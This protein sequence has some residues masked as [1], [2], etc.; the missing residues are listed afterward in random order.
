MSRPR[1]SQRQRVYDAER[2]AFALDTGLILDIHELRA[3]VAEVV[4]SEWWH[5]RYPHIKEII[6]GDGRGRRSACGFLR[7]WD[8]RGQIK[9]PRRFR[10]K[11]LTLHEIAHVITPDHHSFHGVEFVRNLLL[12]IERFLGQGNAELLREEM[13]AGRVKF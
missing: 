9:M 5:K 8:S 1:D 6:V 2:R 13:M 3:W 4:A 10:F 11:W 12:L 7:F